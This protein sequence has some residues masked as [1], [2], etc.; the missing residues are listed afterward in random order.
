MDSE[1]VIADAAKRDLRSNVNVLADLAERVSNIVVDMPSMVFSVLGEIARLEAENER[2][3]KVT[4]AARELRPFVPAMLQGA[5]LETFE[6]AALN[7]LM[8][9]LA[10]YEATE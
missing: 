4:E 3:A 8:D 9:A 2:L 1:R 6:S 7:A 10:A 5:E